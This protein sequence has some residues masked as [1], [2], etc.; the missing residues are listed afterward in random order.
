MELVLDTSVIRGKYP[1]RGLPARYLETFAD[2]HGT[3]VIVPDV[4]VRETKRWIADEI[5]AAFGQV[6]KSATKIRRFGVAESLEVAGAADRERKA[7]SSALA[8]F[9]NQL[10]GLGAHI[11]PI[12]TDITHEQVLDRLHEGQKPFT[13]T[14]KNREKGYRDYL[15]WETILALGAEGGERDKDGRI[16]VAFLTANSSDFG[17]DE[18]ELH[19]ELLAEAEARGVSVTLYASIDEFISEVVEPTLPSSARA[20]ALLGED[21]AKDRIGEYIADQFT[22]FA[23]YTIGS[24]GHPYD[25]EVEDVTI[26]AL[27]PLSIDYAEEIADLPGGTAVAEVVGQAHALVNFYVWKA[28]AYAWA[29]DG[30]TSLSDWNERYFLGETEISV[31]G[32]FRVELV[33]ANGQVQPVDM[34]V[35]ELEASNP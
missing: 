33:V 22:K 35:V 1:L 19:P 25:P 29:D 31:E 16:P 23:P 12:P 4:V 14:E 17:D 26:E 13:G 15:I 30:F 5:G 34:D 20:S 10:R 32:T 6:R 21:A 18:G 9:D 8:D 28:D 27:Y 3:G 7:V 11:A 24:L 2:H